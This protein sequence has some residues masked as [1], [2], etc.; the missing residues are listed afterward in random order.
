MFSMYYLVLHIRT[1]SSHGAYDALRLNCPLYICNLASAT[2][3]SQLRLIAHDHQTISNALK[4]L[5]S[6]FYL[7]NVV[8][9]KGQH[10]YNSLLGSSDAKVHVDYALPGIL[11]A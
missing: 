1:K 4:Y 2:T 6:I 9:C 5:A 8:S 3:A 11:Q 10:D 7:S